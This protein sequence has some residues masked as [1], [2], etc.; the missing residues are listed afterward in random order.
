MSNEPHILSDEDLA[1]RVKAGSLD[2]FDE[3]LSRH[4]DRVYHF[5]RLKVG[6]DQ[7][8]ED[9]TQAT[10]IAAYRS[11]GRYQP[12]HKFTTWLFTI[13]RR[14]AI[15]FYRARR[16]TEPLGEA[17]TDPRTPDQALVSRDACGQI[18]SL[19]RQTLPEHQVTALWLR[20]AEDLSLREMAR[21][22][23][24]TLAHVKVLLHRG[25]RTLASELRRQAIAD[26]PPSL[27]TPSM[28]E[29]IP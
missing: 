25:R 29:T 8:A 20:Y 4:Q 21:I 28:Q 18:W 1:C 14:Q 12:R 9:L 23:G 16:H 10:F 3:L 22:M 2:C 26:A 5:L 19:A 17:G 7:D 13:A 6:Q 11:I 27:A 15:S 24:K